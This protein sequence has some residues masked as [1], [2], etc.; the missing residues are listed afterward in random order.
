MCV[1][2]HVY[3]AC[4]VYVACQVHD[5]C[6]MCVACQVWHKDRGMGQVL[7]L[8]WKSALAVEDDPK[9]EWRKA[10]N[11]ADPRKP[12]VIAFGSAALR[13]YSA[14]ELLALRDQVA[15][16]VA[17]RI[18]HRNNHIEATEPKRAYTLFEPWHHVRPIGCNHPRTM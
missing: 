1:G 10:E 11:R 18:A 17:H 4:Q 15:C 14:E 5:A 7:E 2:L 12:I 16:N 3:L 13:R 8:N 6:R 9:G